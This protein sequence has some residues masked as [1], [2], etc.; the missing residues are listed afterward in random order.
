MRTGI[1]PG[2]AASLRVLPSALAFLGLSAALL[3]HPSARPPSSAPALGQGLHRYFRR[4]RS[5]G[6]GLL[7]PHRRLSLRRQRR[8]HHLQRLRPARR[9]AELHRHPGRAHL[10]D[11]MEDSRRHLR[12]RRGA[13]HGRHGCR[14]RHQHSPIHRPA[15]RADLRAVQLQDRRHQSRARRLGLRAAGD[16]LERRQLPLECRRVRLRADRR[17]QQEA[18]RQYQ[19]QPL[20]GDEPHRRHLLRSEDRLAGERC[21]DLFGQLGEPGDRLRDRQYPQSRRRHHEEFRPVGGGRR[22]ATP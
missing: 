3:S 9:R 6:A 19:P 21:G 16:W 7:F 18:A 11:A 22:S 2:R 12:R 17:L 4:H 8:P 15:R 1:G 10:C 20:G 13:Q 5:A 14:C